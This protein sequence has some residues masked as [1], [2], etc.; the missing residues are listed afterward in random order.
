MRSVSF[1]ATVALLASSSSFCWAS[2]TV[3]SAPY[4][5]QGYLSAGLA[6]VPPGTEIAVGTRLV[7]NRAP[8]GAV[9]GDTVLRFDDGCEVSLKPGQVYT[10]GAGSPCKA[11]SEGSDVSVVSPSIGAPALIGGGFLVAGVVAGV[12]AATGKSAQQSPVYISH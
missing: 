11:A 5:V 2:A 1:I 4:G 8:Q 12:I 6:S 7:V 10:V 9:G 3:K